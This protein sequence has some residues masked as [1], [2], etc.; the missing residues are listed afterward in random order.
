MTTILWDGNEVASDSR[1]ISAG[2]IDSGVTRKIFRNKN[3]IY[4]IAGDYA[5]SL[6][7]MRWM[8][9]GRD[10]LTE[11]VYETPEYELLMVRKG[12]GYVFSGEL[13]GYKVS[14][15]VA[16]GTGREVALGAFVG[17]AGI[18]EA[19][20]TACKLDPNSYPPVKVVKP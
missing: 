10:P 1:S 19:I 2:I 13:E 20:E 18:K 15:P 5:Q 4:A 17:G 12:T 14:P 7:V 11:P 8:S 6:A 16:L 3:V 9:E